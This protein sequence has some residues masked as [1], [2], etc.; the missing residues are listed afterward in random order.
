[1]AD[2][3]RDQELIRASAMHAQRQAL[4]HIASEAENVRQT[5][6][7]QI[8]RG[9]SDGAA[10]TLRQ[11]ANLAAESN[12]IAGTPA[13]QQQ[14]QQQ[15]PQAQQGQQQFTPTEMEWIRRNENVCRDA[16][17]WNETIAA[18][19]SLIARGYD[20]N[21]PEYINAIELAIG[22]TGPDGRDGPEIASGD[23]ALEAVNNSQIAR[24]YGAVTP[25]EYNHY[26][27]HLDALKRAGLRQMDDQ[28]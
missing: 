12:V 17:K 2:S 3:D 1:M 9:D 19:N 16:R 25:A 24:R 13:Q 26:S 6:A 5:Y 11:Y 20:R 21:S 23:T 10:W 22:L 4:Q 7:Q 15:P 14:A 27:Q 18:A 28:S 8:A